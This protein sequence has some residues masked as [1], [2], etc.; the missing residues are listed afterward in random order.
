MRGDFMS[1]KDKSFIKTIE[2]KSKE[3][4]LKIKKLIRTKTTKEEK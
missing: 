1:D 3:E 4:L 2:K